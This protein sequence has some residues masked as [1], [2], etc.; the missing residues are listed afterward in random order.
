MNPWV[1]VA[2]SAIMAAANGIAFA[3]KGYPMNMFACGVASMS[4]F[5]AIMRGIYGL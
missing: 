5:F 4:T 3:Y 1:Q 2:I